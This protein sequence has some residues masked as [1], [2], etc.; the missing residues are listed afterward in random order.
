MIPA[1][2]QYTCVERFLRYV[3]Y[4]TQS[5][6]NSETFPSTEKQKILGADLVKELLAMGIDDA[7]M[8]ENGYVMA[9]LPANTDKANVPVVGFISH[10]DT[11]P[12]VTGENVKPVMHENYDGKDIVLPEDNSIVITVADNPSLK[13]KAG[14]TIITADGTTL[15]G[16]DN[17]AGI[18]EI[19]DAA[20]FLLSHP[21]IKHGDV[22]I[23]FTPDEEVGQ[24]TKF[25]D[26]EKF[27]AKY[28]YTVDGEQLGSIENETFCADSLTVEFEGVSIHP[29]FAKDKLLNSVKMAARFIEKLPKDSLSPETTEN[30][31][32]YVHPHG[33]SGGIETTTIKFLLRAFTSEELR[34]QEAFLRKLVDETVAEF[35]KGKADV[36]VQE[37]YR[38]MRYV[39]DEHPQVLEVAKEAMK[40]IGLEPE[41]G[42]IRGGTDGARLSYMGLPCPNIFAGEHSFH[43]K[44]EW[45]S[46]QDMHK[47]VQTIVTIAAIFEEQ[48]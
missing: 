18:A 22:R 44:R 14:E 35:P 15:L 37:S 11:S 39:L 17:K 20:H 6:E 48:A 38:N 34:E 12:D 46:V 9:T 45:A 21:E 28:A 10:M 26:V 24:G 16:A 47:A 41:I 25:F 40:R 8:D 36:T 2:Y 30:K 33:I 4:D 31:E 13:D 43:S 42:S 5:D 1:D 23:C 3:K 7:A 27:G 32:G 19:V 29:G